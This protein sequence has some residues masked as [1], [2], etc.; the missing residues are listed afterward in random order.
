MSKQKNLPTLNSII[1]GTVDIKR[2]KEFYI[3]VFGIIIE[4]EEA[5]YISAHGVDG[6]HIEIEEDSEQRFPNWKAHN[7][8]TY[9][10]SEFTVTDIHE[11]VKT[12]E[13]SGGKIISQP[14]MRPWGAFGAEIADPDGNI[15]LI[16]SK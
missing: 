11:F 15:F 8:G 14:K 6:T 12:V 10:N 4:K 16:I 9:K 13:K 3:A 1:I 5:V 7:V 2:A